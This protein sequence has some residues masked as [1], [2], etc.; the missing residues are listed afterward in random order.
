MIAIIEAWAE[1]ST[2]FVSRLRLGWYDVIEDTLL[3]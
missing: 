3:A 2:V 1:M